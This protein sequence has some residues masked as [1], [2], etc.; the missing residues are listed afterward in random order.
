MARREH[1]LAPEGPVL[2]RRGRLTVFREA[3]ERWRADLVDEDRVSTFV[4]SREDV[5]AWGMVQLPSEAVVLRPEGGERSF[6][7]WAREVKAEVEPT[8][9]DGRD[10]P[11]AVLARMYTGGERVD[12]SPEGR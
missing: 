5:L 4:G 6:F 7:D 3:D 9:P 11:G 10:V 2:V 12:G 8:L 1:H